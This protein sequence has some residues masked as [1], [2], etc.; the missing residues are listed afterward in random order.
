[1]EE[2]KSAGAERYVFDVRNNPG[3]DLGVIVSILD[4]LLPEGP[5]VRIVD[6]SARW[7]IPILRTK[8]T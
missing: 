2:A 5:I 3:G 4:Y 7:C 8:A 1:M 6:A